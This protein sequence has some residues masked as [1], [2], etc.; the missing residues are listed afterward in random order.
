MSQAL[1]QECEGVDGIL[2]AGDWSNYCQVQSGMLLSGGIVNIQPSFLYEVFNQQLSVCNPPNVAR[3]YSLRWVAVLSLPLLPSSNS[4]LVPK[5]NTHNC[6]LC[7]CFSDSCTESLF[8]QALLLLLYQ[9]F[10]HPISL[11]ETSVSPPKTSLLILPSLNSSMVAQLVKNLPA[12]WET[13]V[14]SLGWEDSLE[15]G[16]GIYSSILA[17][18]IPRTVGHGHD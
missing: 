9:F 12:M 11:N 8:V 16:M 5:Q 7:L 6:K 18:R 13:W 15:K 3:S 17:W 14:Q 10:S 4:I 2:R 1:Q